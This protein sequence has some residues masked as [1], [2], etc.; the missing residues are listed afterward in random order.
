MLELS[1]EEIA[2][3]IRP[4]AN[5]EAWQSF[6]FP[7]PKAKGLTEERSKSVPVTLP[8]GRDATGKITVIPAVGRTSTTSRSYDVYLALVAIWNSRGL[9]DEPV[10]TSVREIVRTMGVPENGKWYDIVIEECEKLFVTTTTWV[11]SFSGEKKY[12]SVK[13]QKVLDTFA[14]AKLEERAEEGDEFQKILSFRLSE[15][16]RENHLRNNT[17][18]ILWSVRKSITSAVGRV[19]YSQIDRALYKREKYERTG[20]NLVVDLMLSETRYRYK[21]KRLEL[22]QKLAKQID[23]K[24]LSNL[25]TVRVYVVETNDKSDYKILATVGKSKALSQSSNLPVLNNDKAYIDA[26]IDRIDE[27]VGG[28]NSHSKLYK[29]F[30]RHYSETHIM[31]AIGEYK[32]A[33][34][35]LSDKSHESKQ[36]HFTVI[37]HR[38]AHRYNRSWIKNCGS[39]CPHREQNKLI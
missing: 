37:M 23:G 3:Y 29:K 6:L 22:L 34:N 16:I 21:S 38:L 17:N 5:L 4:E 11:L 12:E 27:A 32:E 35:Y 26:M 36:K 28:K 7:H 33:K 24:T 8:D 10:Q 30:V 15:K 20:E 14:Y 18:P 39:D 25:R 19:F 1:D 13:Y 2:E 9:P 31:R